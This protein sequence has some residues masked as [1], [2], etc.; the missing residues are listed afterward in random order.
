[1]FLV[2]GHGVRN[3]EQEGEK[4]GNELPVQEF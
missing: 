1:M 2:K 4:E 3:T